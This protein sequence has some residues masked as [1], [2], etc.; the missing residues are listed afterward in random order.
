[1]SVATSY[2]IRAPSGPLLSLRGPEAEVEALRA[3]AKRRRVAPTEALRR[4]IRCFLDAE[5]AEG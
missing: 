4:A 1:M 3:W 5:E 2:A